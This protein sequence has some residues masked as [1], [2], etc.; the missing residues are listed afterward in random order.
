MTR[1]A[2]EEVIQGLLAA[3][4]ALNETIRVVQAETSDAVFQDYRKRTADVM[5][6]IYLD[7]VKPLVRD[8]PDLDPGGEEAGDP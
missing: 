1:A 7:L 6:A 4:G 5:A 2:V 3:S 8:Y